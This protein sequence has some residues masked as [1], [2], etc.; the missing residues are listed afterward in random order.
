MSHNMDGRIIKSTQLGFWYI[1]IVL[2]RKVSGVDQ[3]KRKEGTNKTNGLS[4]KG[5][6]R[7]HRSRPQATKDE[8]NDNLMALKSS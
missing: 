4:P 8:D 2:K 7:I 6:S 1:E 3:R 5:S